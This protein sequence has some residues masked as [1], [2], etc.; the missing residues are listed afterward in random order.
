[1]L[2]VRCWRQRLIATLTNTFTVTN[3]KFNIKFKVLFYVYSFLFCILVIYHSTP[4]QSILVLFWGTSVGCNNEWAR[5]KAFCRSIP[6][7]MVTVINKWYSHT[8]FLSNRLPRNRNSSLPT[9]NLQIKFN[10]NTHQVMLLTRSIWFGCP[11][12]THT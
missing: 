5:C 12:T 1:M 4:N 8:T 2:V 7:R 11:W 10:G 9:T 6:P 3:V